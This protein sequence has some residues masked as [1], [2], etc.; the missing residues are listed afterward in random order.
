MTDNPAHSDHPM[1]HWD[2]TCPSCNP[3]ESTLPALDGETTDLCF[4][5]HALNY[6]TA[7][8]MHAQTAIEDLERFVQA[9]GQQCYAAGVAAERERAADLVEAYNVYHDDSWEA[10]AAAI[11]KG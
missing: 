5:F 2:R 4:G 10:C 11:R 7:H 9:W 3:D 6:R 1:R 8:H